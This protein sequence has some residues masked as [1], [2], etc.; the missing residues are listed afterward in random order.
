MLLTSGMSTPRGTPTR[1][2]RQGSPRIV[3]DI[4][5]LDISR[6]YQTIQCSMRSQGLSFAAIELVL[7]SS[8]STVEEREAMG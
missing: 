6:I 2:S 1:S 3:K 8:V 5:S 4:E 7:E